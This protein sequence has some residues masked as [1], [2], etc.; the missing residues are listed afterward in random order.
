MSRY[1]FTDG[2]V[3]SLA[4]KIYEGAANQNLANMLKRDHPELRNRVLSALERAECF[5][6]VAAE[7]LKEKDRERTTR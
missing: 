4:S 6:E 2:D 1:E 5:F 3:I 7:Y